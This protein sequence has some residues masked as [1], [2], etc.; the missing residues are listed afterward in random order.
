MKSENR[1]MQQMYSD[2]LNILTD[3]DIVRM[4]HEGSDTAYSFLIKKYKK[5]AKTIAQKYYISGGDNEDL[6]Q[7]GMIGIFK[8]VRNFDEDEEASFRTFVEICI[9]RQIQ[10]A[11]TGANR[12]KHKVLNESISLSAGENDDSESSLKD[13]LAADSASF[14]PEEIMVLRDL[15]ERLKTG[16]ESLFSPMEKIIWEELLKGKSY[17]EISEE[18][19][20]SP[21]AVDNAIQRIKK[22]TRFFIHN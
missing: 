19:D 20:K 13:T 1:E 7:E 18:L 21:K 22:K 5:L 14:D 2:D 15:F 9:T 8:A 11:I 12:Q 6:L 4:A 3:E 17:I 16:S 10:T